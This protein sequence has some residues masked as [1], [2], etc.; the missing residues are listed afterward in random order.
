MRLAPLGAA[1][2]LGRDQRKRTSCLYVAPNGAG[3]VFGHYIYKDFAPTELGQESRSPP[4]R[5]AT[6]LGHSENFIQR[7][8]HP[9]A[10]AFPP[11]P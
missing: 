2:G 9:E 10:F 3:R 11:P 4:D 8:P 5:I 6:P 1:S 7:R